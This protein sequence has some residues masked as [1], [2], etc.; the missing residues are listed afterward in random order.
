MRLMEVV[1]V[2]MGG[3][4]CGYWVWRQTTRNLYYRSL[5]STIRPPDVTELDYDRWVIR[6]RKRWRVAKSTLAAA[7]GAAIA[8]VLFTMIDSGLARR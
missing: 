5:H 6:R 3:A 1:V 4:L 8:W 2:V 7:L